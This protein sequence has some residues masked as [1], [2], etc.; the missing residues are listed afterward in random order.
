MQI[1]PQYRYTEPVLNGKFYLTRT[2]LQDCRFVPAKARNR[3]LFHPI[4]PGTRHSLQ[5]RL[6]YASRSKDRLAAGRGPFDV[7]GCGQRS[8][9]GGHGSRAN[10]L[11]ACP[12][13]VSGCRADWRG[14][15][16]RM[17]TWLAASVAVWH[18]DSAWQDSI[19]DR[20]FEVV[21]ENDNRSTCSGWSLD[22]PY[23]NGKSGRSSITF[24]N[25][26]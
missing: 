21:A 6:R 14:N 12:T 22:P 15:P 4:L 16:H 23:S 5:E 26:G 3:L 11:D 8:P 25:A 24:G 2:S 20:D 18:S 13:N 9:G 7:R 10:S 19:P 17:S 1:L